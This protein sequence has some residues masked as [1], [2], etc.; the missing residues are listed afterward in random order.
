MELIEKKDNE[1]VFKVDIDESLANAI[2]RHINELLVLAIDEVKIS[3]N[4]SPLYDETIA[5]RL[6]LM[7]LKID[8]PVTG[9]TQAKFKLNV[10]KEGFVYSGELSPAKVIYNQIPIT[11]LNKGQEIELV[12]TARAGKGSEHSKFSPGLMS[13]RDSLDPEEEGDSKELVISLESFGQ[14]SV[15]SIFTKAIEALKND[16]ASVSK[17]IK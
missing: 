4:D 13:Y 9:K 1:L 6:G 16:L 14:L 11:L 7:P 8:K 2:R 10:K 17:K 12:A 3:K 5:H 15:K